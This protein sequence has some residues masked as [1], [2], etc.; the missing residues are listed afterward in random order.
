MDLSCRLADVHSFHSIEHIESSQ[1]AMLAEVQKG[2]MTPELDAT[3]KKVV[4]EYVL[5]LSLSFCACSSSLALTPSS[6]F[7][8]TLPRSFPP[9]RSGFSCRLEDIR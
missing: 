4:V 3:L 2:K 7:I 9:K 5:S 8:A 1:Q 6:S